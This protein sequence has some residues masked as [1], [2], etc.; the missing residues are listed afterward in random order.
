[1]LNESKFKIKKLDYSSW[2][3]NV[4]Y[5]LHGLEST[6]NNTVKRI[7]VL[8]TWNGVLKMKFIQDIQH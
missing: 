8:H 6:K 7:V 2:G 1:M 5:W 3:I 4:K